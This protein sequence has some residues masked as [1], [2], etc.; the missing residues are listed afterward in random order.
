MTSLRES[1]GRWVLVI[2]GVLMLVG[3]AVLA[4]GAK[5]AHARPARA[6]KC[7]G[8]PALSPRRH[9]PPTTGETVPTPE[10]A[11]Q[12]LSAAY[13]ERP[14]GLDCWSHPPT[15]PANPCRFGSPHGRTTVVLAGN[16]H[17]G[18]WLPALQRIA[19]QQHWRI[20]T[21]LA[22]QCVLA[23]VTQMFPADTERSS[24]RNWADHAAGRVRKDR[25][26]L[27]VYSNRMSLPAE[28]HTLGGSVQAYAAGM[29]RVFR[30]WSGIPVVVL[31]DTPAPSQSGGPAVHVCL[32][33]H[34]DHYAACN[35]TRAEW[36]PPDPAVIAAKRFGIRVVNLNNHICRPRICPAVVGGVIPYVDGSHLTAT[37]ARTLTPF[38]RPP[39]L[40]VLHSR[41][42]RHHR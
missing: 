22:S 24:C 25:P 11:S 6:G 21:E 29:R 33:S 34:P 13:D 30:R 2:A 12:D 16:S 26:D 23:D 27:I 37:F 17:A 9:C 41:G 36:I 39:L 19:Q 40:D 28:H 42:G 8:A 5:A 31:R 18:H 3:L 1:S 38:L 32:Q 4:P 10:R 35:G 7:F 20:L 14:N 15:F